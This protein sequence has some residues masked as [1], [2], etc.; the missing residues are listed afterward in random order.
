MT[1]HQLILYTGIALI[2]VGLTFCWN[3]EPV[4]RLLIHFGRSKLAAYLVFGIGTAWFIYKVAN[5]SEADE[6][7][8]ISREFMLA[9]FIAVS[10]LSFVYVPDFLGVRGLAIVVLLLSMEMLD[11]SWM[12]Y[13]TA[14]CALNIFVYIMV[15]GALYVGAVP[16]KWR[17]FFTWLFAKAKRPRVFGCAFLGYGVALTALAL[18]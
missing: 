7:G 17:D 2:V 8:F 6:I 11:I 12:L 14:Q 5:L 15:V 18:S 3:G 10:L 4:K 1:L 9:I 16:Y 13:S